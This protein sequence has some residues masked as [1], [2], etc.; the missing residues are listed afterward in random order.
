MSIELADLRP[1]GVL[2]QVLLQRWAC[3][4]C[5]VMLSLG[6]SMKVHS[7]LGLQDGSQAGSLRTCSEGQ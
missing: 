2:C 3:T 5:P 6:G 4:G 7:Q 1:Q